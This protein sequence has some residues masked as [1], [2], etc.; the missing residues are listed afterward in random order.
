MFKKVHVEKKKYLVEIRIRSMG[1]AYTRTVD[2][3]YPQ[4]MLKCQVFQD[5]RV[6]SHASE[7]QAVFSIEV[8][9]MYV[10]E[11]VFYSKEKS[12]NK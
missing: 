8:V 2:T 4:R 9:Y 6:V 10:C 7:A 11:C 5:N 3:I 12:K 1:H